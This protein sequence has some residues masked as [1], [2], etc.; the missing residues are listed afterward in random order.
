MALTFAYSID[1][2][3]N[4]VPLVNFLRSIFN[5]VQINLIILLQASNETAYLNIKNI[6]C[7]SL[8]PLK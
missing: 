2:R 1:K 3:F 8:P 4:K 5:D 7:C 6:S